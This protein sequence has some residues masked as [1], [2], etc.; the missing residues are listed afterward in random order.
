MKPLTLDP[1]QVMM[2]V[3]NNSSEL[4]RS[5][6]EKERQAIMNDTTFRDALATFSMNGQASDGGS[7]SGGIT[8]ASTP[9]GS[10]K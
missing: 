9:Y 2:R 8:G 3:M 10:E 7:V 4:R 1:H 6:L 5:Y